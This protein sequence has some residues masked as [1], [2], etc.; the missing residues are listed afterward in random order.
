MYVKRL[1]TEGLTKQEI[2][3]K[4]G[5]SLQTIAKYLKMKN[6]D[7]PVDKGILRERHHNQWMEE[8]QKKIDEVNHLFH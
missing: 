3:M 7:L 5:F 8:R 6:E 4:T 2:R 1:Q